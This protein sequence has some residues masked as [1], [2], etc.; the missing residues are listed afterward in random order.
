[1]KIY[2]RDRLDRGI[3][4]WPVSVLADQVTPD[5]IRQALVEGPYGRCVYACDNDVVDNQVVNL[6]FDHGGTAS[7]TMTAFTEHTGRLTRI[8][9]TLGSID[10]DSNSITVMDFLTDRKTVV[11]TAVKDDGGILT[12]HGGGDFGL[13]E[14]FVQAVAENDPSRIHSGLDETL[15]S[16]LM[17]FA[18]EDSRR[19]GRVVTMS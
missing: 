1:M 16:H 17:V 15:E 2:Q 14:A 4:G 19:T 8:F 6:L 12:G 18:A 3:G 7:M 9:G 11:E 5:S 10:T 13:M